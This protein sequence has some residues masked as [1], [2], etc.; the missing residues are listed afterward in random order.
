MAHSWTTAD[1]PDLSGKTAI[2]TG[3]NS[4]LGFET[5][6]ALAG[7]GARVIMACR[8]QQKAQ[9][10]L[11]AIRA[12]N[13]SSDV[14][15]MSL[16]LADQTSIHAF[17]KAIN[18]QCEA[19]HLLINN[20]GVMALPERRTSEG[21]EM[22]FGTNHLGHFTLTGLLFELL[23]TTSD[24]R[25]VT[26]SSLAHRFGKLRFNDLNWQHGYSKWPAYGQSKLANLMFALELDRRIRAQNLDLRSLAAHPG[27]AS[28]NL[29]Y[30]GPAMTG[31]KLKAQGMK[32]GNVLFSQSQAD[33][34]LPTLYAATAENAQSGKY[35]G[36]DGFQEMWGEPAKAY[37][38][39]PAR[40]TENAKRLWHVS[41]ELT[42][43]K[44][45]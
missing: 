41:E 30:A 2:V 38:N 31:S 43:V 8:N 33:G 6:K 10:A 22:Q 3:A 34:A 42:G 21:F 9:V 11:D 24:A 37:I 40:N 44:F 19:L 15:V 12:E 35:Y 1:M 23:K 13:P 7:A 16:D 17:V 36:P 32:I 45:A 4:G 28:T 26:L 39:A 25:V 14:Q 27:F 5:S 18:A 29:Q 20:A